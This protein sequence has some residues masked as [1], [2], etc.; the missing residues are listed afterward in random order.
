MNKAHFH[1]ALC[2][3]LVT[4]AFWIALLGGIALGTLLGFYAVECGNVLGLGGAMFA[5][6][7]GACALS[8]EERERT[9]D[10]L[11]SHPVSRAQVALQ[12]LAA[13]LLEVLVMNAVLLAVSLVCIA[14]IGE[15]IPYAQLLRL[16]GAYL[17]M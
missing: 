2:F 3:T 14:G 7:T 6:M 16:H 17:L 4:T 13:V 5:A 10:F 1:A 11:L 9:A 12:K 15:E 8:R